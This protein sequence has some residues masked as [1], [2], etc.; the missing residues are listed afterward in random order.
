VT[1]EA[2]VASVTDELVYDPKVDNA[3]ISVS[4]DEGA[5][6]LRGTVSSFRQKREAAKAAAR[7][8]G[9][10]SVNNDLDVRLMVG[11]M[12]EDAALR[13]EVLT[14]LSLDSLVP[15]TVDVSVEDGYVR[16]TGTA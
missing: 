6:T 2:L 3:A 8:Y 10:T 5:V 11:G 1:N 16:L 14:A 9:V 7:V 15:K 12:K 13:A 4:A